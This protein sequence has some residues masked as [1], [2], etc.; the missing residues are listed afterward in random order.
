MRSRKA[1]VVPAAV[2]AVLVAAVVVLIIWTRGG[3]PV[4]KQD[5]VDDF[6]R[7]TTT[8][9]DAD[10]NDE[11]DKG[12]DT[13][14]EVTIPEAGVY[15]YASSGTQEV[16]FGPL[17]ADPRVL[18]DEVVARITHVD[19]PDGSDEGSMSPVL[20]DATAKC[21]EFELKV[22]AEHEESMTT[23]V[24]RSAGDDGDDG[25]APRATIATHLIRM[26]MGP[27]TA[28]G[29]LE[30]QE[31]LVMS[32]GASQEGVPCV[33][34]LT[35]A[36]V[37]VKAD[38][39]GSVTTGAPEM[40]DVGGD[41]VRAV[42]VTL[43]Y[44]AVSADA[45]VTGAWSETVWMSEASWLPLRFDRNIGLLGTATIKETSKL[46]LDSLIPET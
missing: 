3:T 4:P 9:A 38:L 31:L 11:S 6:R 44:D 20:D 19:I 41:S 39:V 23:C 5:A 35:G 14:S 17:P 12:D 16:K 45:K 26:K 21:F 29:H 28:T 13:P 27:V 46:D 33:L 40:V 37:E 42:P 7:T 25:G 1:V 2:V 15:A 36:P 10:A 22:F 8:T 24:S 32:P 18:P 43:S 34:R 30:C